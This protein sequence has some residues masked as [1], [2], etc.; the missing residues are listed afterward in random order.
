MIQ[1]LA[2][3]DDSSLQHRAAHLLRNMVL[4]GERSLCEYFCRSNMLEVIM[5]L[6]QLPNPSPDD[7]PPSDTVTL[8]PGASES[9]LRQL[10]QSDRKKTRECALEALRKLQDYDLVEPLATGA[11]GREEA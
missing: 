1:T 2:G 3:H 7:V 4:C 11:S 5:S 6:S 9:Q 10:I 8:N